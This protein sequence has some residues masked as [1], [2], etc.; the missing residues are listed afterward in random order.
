M[1]IDLTKYKM[2]HWFEDEEGKIYKGDPELSLPVDKDYFTYHSVHPLMM[3]KEIDSYTYHPEHL[4]ENNRLYHAML[5]FRWFYNWMVKRMKKRKEPR[6]FRHIIS[7][8][9]TYDSMDKCIVA[10][11]NSGDYTLGEAVYI[12]AT[13]CERCANVLLYKYLDGKDGYPEG[14]EEWKKCNT[15]CDHCKDENILI[16]ENIT[17][18]FEEFTKMMFKQGKAESEGEENDKTRS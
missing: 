13:A 2:H 8:C 7:G 15:C 16:S 17:K 18:G 6:T 1:K 3:V 12:C 9:T 10:M 14:S 4:H 5:H 11:V